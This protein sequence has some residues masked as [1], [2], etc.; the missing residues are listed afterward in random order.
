MVTSGDQGRLTANLTLTSRRRLSCV[1]NIL[2]LT[3][4]LN[5]IR[6]CVQ[7]N[8][9]LSLFTIERQ[10]IR[11]Y[12]HVVTSQMDIFFD[13]ERSAH[14]SCLYGDQTD[15]I[16]LP[17]EMKYLKGIETGRDGLF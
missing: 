11:T 3:C 10:R 6:A 1:P 2:L 8:T 4:R 14:T 17:E 9:I 7:L 15:I 16:E 13:E 12:I 5:L